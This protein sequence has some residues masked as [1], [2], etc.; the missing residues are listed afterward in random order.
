MLDLAQDARPRPADRA[1]RIAEPACGE[2]FL[3]AALER[4]AAARGIDVAYTGSDL[5]AAGVELAR[6]KVVGELVAGDAT[7]VLAAM[8]PGSQDVVVAKNLLHHIDDPARFLSAAARV[9]GPDG[10]VVIV[11]ARL[12]CPQCFMISLLDVRRERY[13]FRGRRRNVAAMADAG[14]RVVAERRFNVLPYEIAFH[15]RPGLFRR[16]FGT[17][18]R[19]KLDAATALDG[20]L[21]RLVPW[22]SHYVIWVAVPA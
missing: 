3:G 13:F 10:C 1:W 5:S 17:D 9:V 15:I 12:G 11:E 14:V 18:D 19:S 20:R 16:M 21:E 2:G 4:T 8:A 22:L 6:E 7:D